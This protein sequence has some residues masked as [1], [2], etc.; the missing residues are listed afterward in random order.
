MDGDVVIHIHLFPF[1]NRPCCLEIRVAT[2]GMM[3]RGINPDVI[4]DSGIE[5]SRP[6]GFVN[7][8]EVSESWNKT[9][10]DDRQAMFVRVYEFMK[11]PQRLIPS[12]VRLNSINLGNGRCG[13]STLR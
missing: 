5:G 7:G 3:G 8:S 2:D 11:H 12:V 10:R 9:K 4:I 6:T 1:S 13:H